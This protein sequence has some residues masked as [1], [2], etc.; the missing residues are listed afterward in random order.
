M[1]ILL[2]SN[3]YTLFCAGHRQVGGLCMLPKKSLSRQSLSVSCCLDSGKVP[4]LTTT[5]PSSVQFSTTPTYLSCPLI[6]SRPTATPE[7]MLRYK[8]KA[9]PFRPTTCGSPRM[10]WKPAPTSSR[11]TATSNTSMGLP[12]YACRRLDLGAVV[13]PGALQANRAESPV[14]PRRKAATRSAA[15][16]DRPSRTHAFSRTPVSDERQPEYALSPKTQT[17][18]GANRSRMR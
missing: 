10:P 11:R 8:P 6:S 15:V 2:D 12:G 18:G 16:V 7:S 13:T 14:R 3:A 17:A 1:T 5:S 9:A 4:A